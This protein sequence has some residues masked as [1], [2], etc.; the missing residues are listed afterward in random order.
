[1]REDAGSTVAVRV[2]GGGLS[3]DLLSDVVVLSPGIV[4]SLTSAVI[5][6]EFVVL[7]V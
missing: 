1:M 6:K 7:E 3:V 4:A 5:T 2:E